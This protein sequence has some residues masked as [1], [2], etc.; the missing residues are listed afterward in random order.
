MD[1]RKAAD[2]TIQNPATLNEAK[3]ASK[4]AADHLAAVRKDDVE[5]KVRG[6]TRFAGPIDDSCKPLS[7]YI[8]HR[9][10]GSAFV[11]GAQIVEQELA[12][13]VAMYRGATL[14]RQLGEELRP[15]G[16]EIRDR[17]V[18]RES[19]AT[20]DEG[21]RV[22]GLGRA[23]GRPAD[24]RQHLR[25]KDP[26]RSAPKMLA[27]IGAPSLPLHMKAAVFV[28][29]DAPTVTVTF[30]GQILAAL[31]HQRVLRMDE[32][33]FHFRRL[34]RSKSVEAAHGR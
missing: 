20:I 27:L 12:V 15:D 16:V 26:R 25:R 21:M 28:D 32:R 3:R 6:G 2:L 8:E 7:Q 14:L 4:P 13:S 1:V 5:S 31:D 29:C 23:D 11:D 19:P 10:V 33:A 9:P 34:T 17:T 30:P 24:M 18:V 22:F